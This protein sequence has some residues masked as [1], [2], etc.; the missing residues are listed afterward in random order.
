[1]G[2]YYYLNLIKLIFSIKFFGYKHIL[3][4]AITITEPNLY[5]LLFK[6]L[7]ILS[8]NY[9]NPG[10]EFNCV[11]LFKES[12]DEIT[13]SLVKMRKVLNRKWTCFCLKKD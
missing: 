10:K 9:L 3:Q 7:W 8:F 12:L 5:Q 6:N 11:Q 4:M 13:S 1:M 2:I